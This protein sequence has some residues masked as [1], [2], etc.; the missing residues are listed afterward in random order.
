MAGDM[1]IFEPTE[2]YIQGIIRHLPSYASKFDPHA[3]IDWELKVDKEFD[4]HDLSQTQKIYIASNVL[5]EHALMEWKYICRN[6]KV[7][8]YWEDFKLH[9]RD[10]FIPA[11]Y[12]DHLLSKLDTS[13]KGARTVKDYYYDFKICTMFARLDEC[14]EDVMT[15]FMKGLN[16]EIQSIVMHEAYKHISHLFLLACKA[17]NEILLYNY[18]STE[19]VNHSSSFASALH[20]DQEHKIMKPTV[21][22]HHHKKN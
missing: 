21:F 6:N 13:K 5:T 3:Y 17:E 11:N 19:Q 8:Q 12:A 10:A 7:P 1:E 18:T 16:F 20:A 22:F 9:F 14:M 2:H 4:K 15:R